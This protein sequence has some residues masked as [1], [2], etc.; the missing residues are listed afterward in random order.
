ML[1]RYIAEAGLDVERL[2]VRL[3]LAPARIEEL[4]SG[5]SPIGNE[6]ATHIEEMLR[7]PASWLD[8][9][10]PLVIGDST[11]THH[12][13]DT[14]VATANAQ[15]HT[16]T[17]ATDRT[18]VMENRRL[19][20]VMLTSERGTKNRLAQLAGTSG[21][22]ISLM[23]SARKPVSDPFAYAIEDGLGL[24]RGW[25]DQ[26]H[27]EN[28]V[29]PAAWQSLRAADGAA[30][31]HAPRAAPRAAPAPRPARRTAVAPA[32]SQS[33]TVEPVGTVATSGPVPCTAH[34]SEGG[35]T[36]LFDKTPGSCGPIAEALSKTIRYLSATDKLSEARAFQLL[37]VLIAKAERPN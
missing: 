18:Q 20:L 7:L 24:P 1:A 8:Q 10:G 30:P 2:A 16:H 5:R 12:L 27:V 17:Q 14:A 32:A 13:D 3:M 28:E 9:G 21:S 4:I 19:N 25:L 34:A 23:T 11:M 36:G 35:A 6:L 37:G 31:E 26:L 33:T 15:A 22:R 29:P